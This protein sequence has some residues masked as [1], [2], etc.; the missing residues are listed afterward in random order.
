M[1]IKISVENYKQ[2]T[3]LCE[4]L[5][6]DVNKYNSIKAELA[7]KLIL[8]LVKLKMFHSGDLAAGR[9]LAPIPQDYMEGGK[10]DCR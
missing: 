8:D 4:E 1:A 6:I 7:G 3:Q 9:I 2:I 10:Y 5:K